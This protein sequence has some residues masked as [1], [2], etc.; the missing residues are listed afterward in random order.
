MSWRHLS[1]PE[2][3]VQVTAGAAALSAGD[4]VEASADTVIALTDGGTCVGV[5]HDDAD[6]N[7]TGVK[8]DKLVPGAVWEVG[9]SSQ[10]LNRHALVYAAGSG[11]V[12]DGASTNIAIGEIVN[13]KIVATDT[14]A[15]VYIL[16]GLFAHA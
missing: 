15:Q 7:E 3:T 12:D 5:M 2:V 9:V 10:T 1:G 11:N 14:K 8:M 16:G 4:P 6:A 13:A